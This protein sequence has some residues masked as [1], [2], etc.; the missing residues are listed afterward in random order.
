LEK[1]TKERKTRTWS[2]LHM[3]VHGF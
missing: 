3:V 1:G 2:G